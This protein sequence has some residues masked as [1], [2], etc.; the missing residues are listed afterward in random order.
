MREMRGDNGWLTSLMRTLSGSSMVAS[1]VRKEVT[2]VIRLSS[3]GTSLPSFKA[4]DT[5]SHAR[6]LHTARGFPFG[7]RGW[8]GG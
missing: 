2:L 1:D 3:G 6:A 8:V 4:M 7:E 5:L